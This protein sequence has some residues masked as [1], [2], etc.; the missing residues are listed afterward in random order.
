MA[1]RKKSVVRFDR[2]LVAVFGI[3][4]GVVALALLY[5]AVSNTTDLRSKAAQVQQ[6][7]KQWE[8]NGS[9]TE[10]WQSLSPHSVS[11]RNGALVVEVGKGSSQL[12]I[13]RNTSVGASLP[14]GLKT[15]SFSLS[16]GKIQAP[17]RFPTG[18]L[19]GPNCPPAPD[20]APGTS[21]IVGSTNSM[22]SCPIYR[23]VTSPTVEGQWH[24]GKAGVQGVTNVTE[25]AA[26]QQTVS[27]KVACT[28]DAKLCPDGTAVGRTAPNCEFL[29]CPG[30]AR[31]GTGRRPTAIPSSGKF[32]GQLYYQ[33]ANK[34]SFERPVTFSGLANSSMQPISVTL[35]DIDAVDVAKIRVVFTSGVRPGEYINV[36]W[37]RLIGVMNTSSCTP[38]PACAYSADANA[39]VCKIGAAPP[40]GGSWCPRP[41]PTAGVTRCNGQDG[42]SCQIGAC[43]TCPPG[44]MCPMM[45]CVLQEGVCK[46][47]IC[48]QAYP[49]R[50]P[51][52]GCYYQQVQCFRA[53]CDPI[54]VCPTTTCTPPPPECVDRNGSISLCDPRPGV[55]WCAVR[56]WQLDQG[57]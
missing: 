6:I 55:T 38:L 24:R 53:P 11:V 20:C 29:P 51:R 45:A 15:V 52:P 37:V 36:D 46:S 27:E 19:P 49:T 26:L 16:V 3:L 34:K 56:R 57:Q 43:P 39:S 10:G 42:S 54:L 4:F 44:R 41:T 8:F 33:L 2:I 48:V 30:D 17:T 1:S 9:D 12:P 32:T 13:F 22:S 35:P 5:Q 14:R 28:M 31:G 18:R 23:C 21:L 50:P 47:G 7:Y 25:E 40:N